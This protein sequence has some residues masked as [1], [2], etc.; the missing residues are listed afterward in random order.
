MPIA[1]MRKLRHGGLFYLPKSV[2]CGG[3]IRIQVYLARKL[4][5]SSWHLAVLGAGLGSRETV[6]LTASQR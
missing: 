3:R 1:Q 4:V 5:C 6:P 2:Q